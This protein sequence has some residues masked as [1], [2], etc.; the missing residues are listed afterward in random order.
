M[1][2]RQEM[3]PAPVRIDVWRALKALLLTLV[4][5]LSAAVIIDLSTGL[6]PMVTIVGVVVFIPLAAIVVGRIL[7]SEL[8]RVIALVA[9]EP[10]VEAPEATTPAEV[11]CEA[12]DNTALI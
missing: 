11:S 7:L 10:V 9:P 12:V 1:T 4:I 6:L 2:D 8:D 3:T 5:P